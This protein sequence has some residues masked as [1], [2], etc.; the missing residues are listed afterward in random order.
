MESD[1][2]SFQSTELAKDGIVLSK[3]PVLKML[4]NSKPGK[5]QLLTLYR[6]L[7]NE[8]KRD[9]N[10]LYADV[11]QLTNDDPLSVVMRS[12]FISEH[13]HDEDE[14]RFF[15]EGEVLVYIHVNEKVH[16]LQCGAGDLLIIPRKVKHWMDI[17]PMPSFTAIRWYSTPEGLERDFTGSCVAESTPRWESIFSELNLDR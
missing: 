2:Y 15:I 12:Q 4:P 8:I 3:R 14:T 17:G 13:T 16:I 5:E 11:T 9:Y 7:V 10:Y 6:D 1:D